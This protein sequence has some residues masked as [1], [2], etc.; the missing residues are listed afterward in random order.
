MRPNLVSIEDQRKFKKLQK[1]AQTDIKKLADGYQDPEQRIKVLGERLL[2]EIQEAG[3]WEI[4]LLASR[5]NLEIETE[6]NERIKNDLQKEK[7]LRKKLE[8][9]CHELQ[10]QNRQIIDESRKIAEEEKQK[11][12]SL[13]QNFQISITEI[14]QKLEQ[15]NQERVQLLQYHELLRE[16]LKEL[17]EHVEKQDEKFKGELETKTKMLEEYKSQLEAPPT[18]EEN[19]MR[20]QLE[21]YKARFEE[22]Q[23]SLV[24]SNEQFGNFKKDMDGKAKQLR[25]IQKDS[26][27]VKKRLIESEETFQSMQREVQEHEKAKAAMLKDI[28]KLETLKSTLES[29]A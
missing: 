27:E 15:N 2:K 12:I 7:Q 17:I 23:E 28:T 3:K 21:E 20:K 29:G 22:F 19:E 1:K 25:Q 13:S 4:E 14:S 24:N 26:Q 9:F 8:N 16:K 10:A 11:R 18:E 5:E 6:E